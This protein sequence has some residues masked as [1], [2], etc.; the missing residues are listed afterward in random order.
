MPDPYGRRDL[1][2]TV[3]PDGTAESEV[4]FADYIHN[5]GIKCDPAVVYKP[6]IVDGDGYGI[7]GEPP[8]VTIT[9]PYAAPI[10]RRTRNFKFR[11]SGATPGA[12]LEVRVYVD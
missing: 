3:A 7:Y 5:Y 9:G 12:I 4:K 8:D 2:L 6:E 1:S 10:N 11:V